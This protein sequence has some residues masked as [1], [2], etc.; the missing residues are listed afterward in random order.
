MDRALAWLHDVGGVVAVARPARASGTLHGPECG[1]RLMQGRLRWQ[2]AAAAA[3]DTAPGLPPALMDAA[4][5]VLTGRAAH[6]GVGAHCH[7]AR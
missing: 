4:A 6:G 2:L 7:S 5:P 1:G 3:A